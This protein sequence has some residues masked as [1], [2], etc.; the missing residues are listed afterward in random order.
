M[1]NL[2]KGTAVA[3]V[4]CLECGT[5][6]TVKLDKNGRGYL[7]CAGSFEDG[8]PCNARHHYSTNAS[9]KM[10]RAYLAARDAKAGS[11][12][13]PKAPASKEKTDG[14]QPAGVQDEP[15]PASPG[16]TDGEFAPFDL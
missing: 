8:A 4:T 6:G 14:R 15:K 10:Q 2:A 3:R 7:Y 13:T 16:K 5:P 12:P 1:P 9:Q 11:Q